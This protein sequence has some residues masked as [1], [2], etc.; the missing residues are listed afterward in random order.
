MKSEMWFTLDTSVKIAGI[1][2]Q[3]LVYLYEGTGDNLLP[4]DM[5]LGYVDY[6]NY[7][8]YDYDKE[9]GEC[10]SRDGGMILLREYVSDISEAQALKELEDELL[11]PGQT[12]GLITPENITEIDPSQLIGLDY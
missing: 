11:S 8:L 2:G 3:A 4:T 10:T 12:A 1:E 7:D 6:L 5:R 9:T